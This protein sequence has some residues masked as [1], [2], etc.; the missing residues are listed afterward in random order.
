MSDKAL[1]WENFKHFKLMHMA[2]LDAFSRLDVVTDGTRT[3]PNATSSDHGPSFR[4]IVELGPEVHA[5][6]VYPGGQSGN[7]GSRFYDSMVEAW[8]AGKYYDLLF[9]NN[10]NNAPESRVLG[11]VEFEAVPE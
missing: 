5:Q 8:A 1:S 6:G 9:M 11:S 7:P 10:K 4:M 3:S 2:R